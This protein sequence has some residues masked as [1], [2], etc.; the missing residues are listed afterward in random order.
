MNMGGRGRC[1]TISRL[2]CQAALSLGLMSGNAFAEGLPSFAE[3][4]AAHEPSDIRILDRHGELIHRL[5][6]NL[7]VRKGQWIS[8]EA[9]SPAFRQA[10]VLSE[11][12]RFYE[13]SG[14]DWRA[15]SSAAWGNLWNQKTRGASTL[16][17]QLVGLLDEELKSKRTGRTFTKKIEQ[18][19]TAEW[20]EL[21]WRKDQILEA[22]LNLVPFRGE[23][24]GIDALSQ[25]LFGK[26]AQGLND[27]DAAIA[28]ALVRGPNAAPSEIARRACGVLR[29]I[30]ANEP[31]TV[32]DGLDQI[33]FQV[34][35]R[36]AFEPSA[37]IAPHFARYGLAQSRQHL[38]TQQQAAQDLNT[39]VGSA[40]PLNTLNRNLRQ[41]PQTDVLKTKSTVASLGTSIRTTIDA[42]TQRF[43]TQS[44]QGQLRE[45]RKRHVEDGGVVVLDN[46]TGEILA[47][48]GSSGALSKAENVDTVL[49]LRQPGS[50]LKPFLYAQAI[51]EQRLTA[52]SLLDDSSAQLQ[53]G[54]GLYIPQNYDRSFK[55]WV[56]ARTALAASL[57]LPAVRTLMMVTPDAFSQQLKRVGL[58]L[59]QSGDFYGYS[60][61]LGSAEVS[62]LNLTNAYRTLANAGRYTPLTAQLGSGLVER[63]TDRAKQN[64][65]D[66]LTRDAQAQTQTQTQALDQ[67]AAFIVS[68][69]LS[70]P[71][72]RAG[73]FGTDSVLTTRFWSAVKTGTSKDMRD[74]WAIGYSEHYTVGVWVGNANG[75]PMWDVSGT[76]GAAPVWAEVMSYLHREKSSAPPPSPFGVIQQAVELTNETG[77]YLE[78]PYREWFIQGTE[79]ALFTLKRVDSPLDS[80]L[81]LQNQ[82]KIVAPTNGTILALDPDIPNSAQLISLR[83][84]QFGAQHTL[85]WAINDNS[86]AGGNSTTWRPWPG[87][88]EIALLDGA[89]V[90]LDRIR[91]E[92]RGAVASKTLK[93]TP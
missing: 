82:A 6:T 69:I 32:C 16:T 60:L 71:Y 91:I 45:L 92:V 93:K 8:L 54:A 84:E 43:A 56:S 62:L 63:S 31:A 30:E 66:G 22:Y 75:T 42:S 46:K 20:L 38:Q 1:C 61:A 78:A 33:V 21:K 2:L 36:K 35:Q 19:V 7:S 11:D 3:V 73:T 57:N 76:T 4:K 87:Q 9:I 34:L 5:R 26:T 23:T 67:R 10:I 77:N 59:K 47:W 55:G 24:V 37:G 15:V 68:D 27:Q 13:H 41:A 64:H 74:N 52:A 90:V 80:Q 25:T 44:L 50:T 49:A 88:H 89:G 40:E 86:L 85:R 17:M 14:V 65:R 51:A 48:V 58:P 72:A 81:A 83:A 53:T 28:A 18:S 79:Q 29:L 39:S 12:K 70:D